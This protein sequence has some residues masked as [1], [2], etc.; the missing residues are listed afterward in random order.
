MIRSLGYSSRL[1]SGF[2]ARPEKYDAKKRHT[3]VHASDAHFWCE[4]FV[5]LGTWVTVEATPGYDQPSPPPKLLER[6][7]SSLLDGIR[8]LGHHW[9]LTAGSLVVAILGFLYQVAIVDAIETA[10]CHWWPEADPASR[11]RR[12]AKLIEHRLRRARFVRPAGMTLNRWIYRH[13]TTQGTIL[14]QY[15]NL[16]EIAMFGRPETLQSQTDRIRVVCREVI[17]LLSQQSLLQEM[18]AR[19]RLAAPGGQ[20]RP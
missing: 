16:T 17:S 13:L 11:L 7:T 15:L 9:I 6:I 18:K 3:P 20:L 19:Q 8:Y 1:V 4:V 2:Y 5:G 12:V 14:P 10:V